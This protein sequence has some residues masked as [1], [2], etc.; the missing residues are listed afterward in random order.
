[1]K[2]VQPPQGP[3]VKLFSVIL[4]RCASFV[5]GCAESA[6]INPSIGGLIITGRVCWNRLIGLHPTGNILKTGWTGE[7][8]SLHVLAPHL[9]ELLLFLRCLDALGKR[10]NLKACGHCQN[11]CDHILLF[12]IAVNVCDER[13][14][15]FNALNGEFAD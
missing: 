2:A 9:S 14:V 13:T 3:K 7:G 8:E 5:I 12:G 1:M 10:R 4:R 11:R 6:L 15:N